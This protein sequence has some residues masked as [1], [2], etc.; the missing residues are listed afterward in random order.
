MQYKIVMRHR[1]NIGYISRTS[2]EIISDAIIQTNKY[3]EYLE[4]RGVFKRC[5]GFY[6]YC[7]I[8]EDSRNLESNIDTLIQNTLELSKLISCGGYNWIEV[9]RSDGKLYTSRY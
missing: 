1:N 3:K 5:L 8:L 6:A 2:S 9:I 7:R 4:G